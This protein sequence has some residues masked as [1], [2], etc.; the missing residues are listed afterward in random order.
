MT[1]GPESDLRP[2]FV[3]DVAI[4]QAMAADADEMFAVHQDAI[5]RF[6]ADHYGPERMRIWF[7]GRTSAIYRQALE[8]GRVWLAQSNGRILGFVGIK[9]GEIYWLYVREAAVGHG[10]GTRLLEFGVERARAGTD[11]PVKVTALLNAESFYARC[12]F[13]KIADDAFERGDPPLTYPVVKMILNPLE[14][15]A[16]SVSSS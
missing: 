1:G 14:M 2:V 11:E 6:S 12:G 10:I 9:P 8:E 4:R 16:A 3:G 15:R 13:V 5:N 7:V